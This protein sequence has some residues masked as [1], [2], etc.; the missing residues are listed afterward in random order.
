M[1]GMMVIT[2]SIA[3]TFR[4]VQG[5]ERFS[6]RLSLASG[7]LSLGFGLVVAYQICAT[8]GLLSGHPH[9]TPR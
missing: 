8:N 5:G 7:L 3:S 9:W 4:L 6:R 2:M 1:A